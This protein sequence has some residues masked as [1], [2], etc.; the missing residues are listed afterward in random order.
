M[1][2]RFV[3]SSPTY[4]R[5]MI[6][7]RVPGDPPIVR[8]D[9]VDDRRRFAQRLIAAQTLGLVVLIGLGIGPSA[10]AAEPPAAGK[11]NMTLDIGSTAPTWEPLEGIDGGRY[12]SDDVAGAPLTV[13]VFTCN[14]CPYAVDYEDRLVALHRR[15]KDE[16]KVRIVAINSNAIPDDSLDAMRERAEA[17]SFEFVYLKDP[18]SK[19]AEAFGAVRTPE[20]FLLDAERKVIYMGAFDDASDPEKV[21]ERHLENAIDAHLAGKPIETAETAPVGCL[22]RRPRPRR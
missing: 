19:L 11:Y 3:L 13:V 16:G 20:W 7:I 22:V 4:R 8:R 14:G 18:E 17:K 1:L 15:W 10:R 9:R 21:T 6:A 12:G 2:S 5:S